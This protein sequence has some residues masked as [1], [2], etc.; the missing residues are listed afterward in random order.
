MSLKRIWS[1]LIKRN[2]EI[3]PEAFSDSTKLLDEGIYPLQSG[4][5]YASMSKRFVFIHWLLKY[6]IFVPSIWLFNSIFGKK[7]MDEVPDKWQWRNIKI[8]NDTWKE[9]MDLMSVHYAKSINNHPE[10][11]LMRKLIITMT[12][13]DSAIQEAVNIFCHQLACNMHKQYAPKKGSKRVYH[14][15]YTAKNAYNP[16]YFSLAKMAMVDKVPLSKLRKERVKNRMD[17]Y[18]LEVE[19][20]KQQNANLHAM[21][22]KKQPNMEIEISYPTLK[23]KLSAIRRV[24]WGKMTIKVKND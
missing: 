10:Y 4:E 14:V 12:M 22:Q 1:N 16:I 17:M 9:T 6:K 5:T 21:L 8:F 2:N 3:P 18:A 19:N 20:L 23:D 11:I 15:L 7:L 24:L 13:Y